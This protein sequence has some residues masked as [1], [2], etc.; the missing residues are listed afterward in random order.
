MADYVVEL[1]DSA[2]R[3]TP[4]LEGDFDDERRLAL[5]SKADAERG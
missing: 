2:F 1:K 5:D 3:E 4:F